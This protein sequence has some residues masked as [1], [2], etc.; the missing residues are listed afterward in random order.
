MKNK[1][2]KMKGLESNDE[3]GDQWIFIAIDV[4]NK[5]VIHWKVGKRTL[6]YAKSF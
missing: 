6:E 3:I 4:V 5:I 2:A 1:K